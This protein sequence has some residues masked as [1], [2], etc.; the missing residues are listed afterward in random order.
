VGLMFPRQSG[1]KVL[2]KDTPFL[3]QNVFF[4]C[5]ESETADLQSLKRK[6]NYELISFANFVIVVT[7]T[8]F[9]EIRS[10]EVN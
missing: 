9:T 4:C 2:K 7:N 5:E 6:E 10:T 3:E 8:I 1:L